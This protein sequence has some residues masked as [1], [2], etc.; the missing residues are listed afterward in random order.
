MSGLPNQTQLLT[1]G[2]F[3]ALELAANQTTG[4]PPSHTTRMV[5]SPCL[6]GLVAESWW[7]K[8]NV[9]MISSGPDSSKTQCLPIDWNGLMITDDREDSNFFGVVIDEP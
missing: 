2:T 3:P 9:R 6:V 4:Q 1:V 5:R 7:K 8:G